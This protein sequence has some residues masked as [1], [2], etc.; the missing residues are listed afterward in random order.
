MWLLD[1]KGFLKKRHKIYRPALFVF[2]HPVDV[3]NSNGMHILIVSY[4]Y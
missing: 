4:V 2:L 1:E 3:K